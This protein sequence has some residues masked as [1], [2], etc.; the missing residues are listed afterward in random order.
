ML[1]PKITFYKRK[2]NLSYHEPG[3]GDMVKG[4]MMST[5]KS[6]DPT[7]VQ[8]LSCKRLWVSF[9]TFV[10]WWGICGNKPLVSLESVNSVSALECFPCILLKTLG[11]PLLLVTSSSTLFTVCFSEYTIS[12]TESQFPQRQ[13]LSSTL[14]S[15]SSTCHSTVC[16]AR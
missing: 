10:K 3:A 8:S 5:A 7:Q 6:E 9:S 16:L 2:R 1:S 12:L 13:W 14:L 11:F 15:V 4:V